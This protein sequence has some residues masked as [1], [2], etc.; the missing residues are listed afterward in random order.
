[1]DAFS[2][3]SVLISI[4]IGLAITQVL[5]G[6]R[7][8]LLHRRKVKLYWPALLQGAVLL[9]IATQMWWAMFSLRA[10][11][12]WTFAGYGV[13]L[14]QTVAFYLAAGLIFPDV[15]E[16]GCD[17]EQAYFDHRRWFFGAL[18][19]TVLASAVK[20]LVI[21]GSLPQSWDMALHVAFLTASVAA[22]VTRSRLYHKLLAPGVAMIFAAYT[23]MLFAQ[24]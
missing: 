17:L 19:L 11:T 23:F 10:I 13:V 6:F 15:S 8:I 5:M 20:D 16:A 24:L 22:M 4:I 14:L 2:Y 21:Y 3:L 18:V 9:L 1:M 7:A 12:E